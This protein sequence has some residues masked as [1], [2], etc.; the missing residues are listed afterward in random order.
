MT[1]KEDTR[2][3][4]GDFLNDQSDLFVVLGVFLA[5]A[6][7]LAQ[8]T[9]GNIGDSSE[10]LRGGFV[11]A[12]LLTIIVSLVILKNIVDEFGSLENFLVGF[13]HFRNFDLIVFFLAFGVLFQSIVSKVLGFPAIVF[14]FINAIIGFVG[15]M[16]YMAA[17][18]Y[19]FDDLLTDWPLHRVAAVHSLANAVGLLVLNEFSN[20]IESNYRIIEA[21]EFSINAIEQMLPASGVLLASI[22]IILTGM[23]LTI[24]L[25]FLSIWTIGKIGSYAAK[26]G[27]FAK[28]MRTA[29]KEKPD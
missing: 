18:R 1:S 5:I 10:T 8:I 28:N 20:L 12:L 7:Y 21:S 29:N 15:M 11:G 3:E 6:V 19:T 26:A 9:E 27:Q 17:T 4:L 22:L 24:N 25:L 2:F 16:M 23:V 14:Y 13:F